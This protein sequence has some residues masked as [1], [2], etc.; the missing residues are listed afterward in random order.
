MKKIFIKIA[1]CLLLLMA[2]GISAHADDT[3]TNVAF[4]KPVIYSTEFTGECPIW[5]Y[6]ARKMPKG[7]YLTDGVMQG[8]NVWIPNWIDTGVAIIDLAARYDIRAI[9]LY[10]KTS[11]TYKNTCA[12]LGW[13]Y[14]ELTSYTIYASNDPSFASGTV[15]L[16]SF[17]GAFTDLGRCD[18]FEI[19]Q[20]ITA[21]R[22]FRYIK[23]EIPCDYSWG[24]EVSELRVYAPEVDYT[25]VALGRGAYTTAQNSYL[26]YSSAM[27]VDD[28]LSSFWVWGWGYHTWWQV[29]LAEQTKIWGIRAYPRQNYDDGQLRDGVIILADNAN[30]GS[31]DTDTPTSATTLFRYGLE[32]DL[33][34]PR[35]PMNSYFAVYTPDTAEKYSYIRLKKP[36]VNTGVGWAEVQILTREPLSIGPL[37]FVDMSNN[38]P[39]TFIEPHKEIGA[40]VTLE[41]NFDTNEKAVLFVGLYDNSGRLIGCDMAVGSTTLEN[42]YTL[43]LHASVNTGKFTGGCAKAFLWK[44][45]FEPYVPNAEIFG[46]NIA[47]EFHVSPFGSD[48]NPGTSESPFKTIS[49]AMIAV[50]QV[51]TDMA[52]DIDVFLDD[53]VYTL[54]STLKFGVEDG[55]NNNYRVNYKAKE[56]ANPVISGGVQVSG[57]TEGE[58]GIWSASCDVPYARSLYINDRMAIRARTETKIKGNGWYTDSSGKV[59]GIR[60]SK[61][62][63]GQL[64]NPE[65]AEIHWS[66]SW[67]YNCIK[68]SGIISVNADE[69]TLL[70]SINTDDIFTYDKAFTVENAFELLD[71]EGEFY[72]NRSTRTIYYKPYAG[73]DMTNAVGFVPRVETLIKIYSNDM[74]N[75]VKNISFDGITFAYGAYTLPSISSYS[76]VQANVLNN[77]GF[78]NPA[79]GKSFTSAS[80]QLNGADN[81]S[82]TNSVFK[83]FENA[84]VGMYNGVVNCC[85]SGNVFADVADSAL[86]VGLPTHNYITNLDYADLAFGKTAT[87]ANSYNS[88]VTPDAVVDD[89]GSSGWAGMGSVVV[90]LGASYRIHRVSIV[91]RQDMDVEDLRKNF[92][93]EASNSSDFSS[94]VTLGSQGSTALPYKATWS[95]EVTD[96]G[97]YRYVRA[98]KTDNSFFYVAD[99]H[100]Y[101]YEMPYVPYEEVCTNNRIDN[102]IITRVGSH[103]YGAPAISAY[104]VDS[105]QIEHNYI[106]NLPYTAISLGWGW[107]S[108]PDSTTCKN[109]LVKNNRI[110]NFMQEC[111]DGGGIY[112][113][114]NQPGTVVSGNFIKDAKNL[115]GLLYPDEGSRYIEF[116]GNVL[117]GGLKYLHIWTNSIS[118]IT[119]KD[120]YSDT[121]RL[122]NAG[123]NITITGTTIYVPTHRPQAAQAI[124]DNA[125]ITLAYAGIEEKVPDSIRVSFGLQPYQNVMDNYSSSR[126][127]ANYVSE[128]KSNLQSFYN[129]CVNSGEYP[130]YALSAL[131]SAINDTP[132]SALFLSQQQIIDHHLR[133]K[134]ALL[135]FAASKY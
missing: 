99:L 22:K 70:C 106:Y 29:Q 50:R 38:H 104:Y 74:N 129:K 8:E 79:P 88:S 71:T 94:Y 7:S 1:S 119:V 112:T 109:N 101:N 134:N 86:T 131:Q 59:A 4:W 56:G 80:I 72:Y 49:R 93:V 26:G 13:G 44:D 126:L 117:E 42:D 123:T 103:F 35:I 132:S 107:N 125:G 82:F 92:V 15:T 98:R 58:N 67:R 57:W 66:S 96:T 116:S 46:S 19:G 20:N 64:T 61:S 135:A 110:E 24:H 28:N 36:T 113:M 100:V 11:N 122:T 130:T 32:Y 95:A 12:S 43:S 121:H 97:T 69:N 78:F 3:L 47:K 102:N 10:H 33:N 48:L 41:A 133:L 75:K 25:N 27:A 23:L 81:I 63:I 89:N 31:Y 90:D 37:T 84:A 105:L 62:L 30:M 73:E 16:A 6:D 39:V 51:N 2:V 111:M 60:I 124:V 14:S 5:N 45:N 17:S 91:T 52:C 115:E 55:G 83:C 40:N 128:E 54:N 118:D 77:S 65:D 21:G 18:R 34:Q 9:E 85:I 76:S 120:N 127:F 87:A 114:G 53:G 108:T 68:L